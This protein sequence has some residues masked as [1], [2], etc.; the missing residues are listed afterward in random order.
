MAISGSTSD[1]MRNALNE[2]QH[3][4]FEHEQW[5]DNIHRAL[6]CA[7]N[8]DERDL[9]EDAHRHCRLG[10]WL[11]SVGAKDI[12]SCSGFPRI[13]ETHE[14]MHGYARHLLAMSARKEPISLED[15]ELFLT[16]S[17]AMRLE[18]LMARRELEDAY[19][20]LSP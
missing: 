7:E 9:K 19:I 10:Q 1:R 17:K 2:L 18:L 13:L 4:F 8:P 14:A 15:Y 5:M 6:V 11:Y 16:T 12:G 20:G 3:A